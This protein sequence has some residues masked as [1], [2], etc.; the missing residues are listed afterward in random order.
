MQDAERRAIS[1]EELIST[2]GYAAVGIVTFL[3]GGT[4]LIPG[5]FAAHR[6]Y[7]E[8][9]WVIVCALLGTFIGDQFYFYLG[10][11]RGRSA[12]EKRCQG[13]AP[14]VRASSTRAK[15][16]RPRTRPTRW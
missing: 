3:E 1:L 15:H 4:I 14:G 2:Y 9:P 8:L 13:Q 10:R 7:L 12:L 5:G 11:T 16:S 6:G